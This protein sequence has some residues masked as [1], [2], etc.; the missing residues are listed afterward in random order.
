MNEPDETVALVRE[1]GPVPLPL[2]GWDRASIWG[3]D[4]ITASL[5]AH[6]WRN[7]D[8]P[9]RPPTIRIVPDDFTPAIAFAAT[10]AQH[11]AM[12]ADCDPWDVLTALYEVD[13]QGVGDD[14]VGADEAGT[15]V[16]MTEGHD[17]WRPPN[18]PQNF[19][20]QRK[21]PA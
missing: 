18:A 16:T 12:A 13:D 1:R 4:E 7:T 20:S 2:E 8:D 17:I 14:D 9:A 11:I 5:Y 19:G 15:V 3:W 21:R 6:L 10:L